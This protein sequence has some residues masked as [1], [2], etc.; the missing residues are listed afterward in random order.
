MKSLTGYISAGWDTSSSCWYISGGGSVLA[1]SFVADVVDTMLKGTLYLHHFG[2]EYPARNIAHVVLCLMAIRISNQ[3][4]HGA[5]VM[6][7]LLYEM[8][9]ILRLYLSAG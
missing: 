2:W 6:I 8:S 1:F 4:F 5:L 9:Y 3:T 7:F